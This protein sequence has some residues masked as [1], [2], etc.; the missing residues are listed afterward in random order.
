[1]SS[2]QDLLVAR[3]VTFGYGATSVLAGL[4]LTVAA[5][6]IYGLLGTNGAGKSTLIQL[7]LGLLGRQAG[8]L[9]V[10]GFDPAATGSEA[11]RR[12]AYVPE[13]VSAYPQL[14]G[15]EN[16]RYFLRLARTETTDE[17]T[18]AQALAAVGLPEETWRR[19]V[20]QYSKGM[21]QKLVIAVAVARRVPLLLLDEPT[22]GLDP[23]A[24]AEFNQLL[25]R[26]KERGVATLL[27]SHDLLGVFEVADR[28]GFLARG[29]VVTE[30]AASGGAERFDLNLLRQLYNEG[31]GDL[32]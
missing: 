20:A 27:V 1:V 8:T 7:I 16:L 28:L 25:R 12:L 11:R 29:R 26:L 21:R 13:S 23:A 9:E 17:A 6:E 4:D 22:S 30:V 31:R 19:R 5:G 3:G 24:M 15:L 32:R 14:S 10:A 18:L 2:P